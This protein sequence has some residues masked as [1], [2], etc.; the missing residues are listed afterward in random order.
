MAHAASSPSVNALP[1]LPNSTSAS[2]VASTEARRRQ[3]DAPSS[4]GTASETGGSAAAQVFEEVSVMNNYFGIGLDAKIASDFHNLR[5]EHPEKF[6]SR[7]RN[8]MWYGM[9]GGREFIN[10]TFRALDQHIE[11]F[12][13]GKPVA[14][15]RLQGLVV[16][17]IPSYMGGTDFWGQPDSREGFQP[18]QIDDKTL[19]VMAVFNV[20]QMGMARVGV[21]W[22]T[23]RIAQCKS[24]K[25]NILSSVDQVPVQVDGEA[26]MQE[27]GCIKVTHKGQAQMLAR[28]PNLSSI[29]HNWELRRRLRRN[30]GAVKEGLEL[31]AAQTDS[32]LGGSLQSA[33]SSQGGGTPM[34]GAPTGE[35]RAFWP[36]MM[37]THGAVSGISRLSRA[38]E[39]TSRELVP[40]AFTAENACT[41]LREMA[42][43]KKA[44]AAAMHSLMV[45]VVN[46][47]KVSK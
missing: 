47:V 38:V 10:R 35:V 16:L 27:P 5:E 24:L 20:A 4:N 19:E 31:G 32:G 23:A 15:P 14:L 40:L 11:L 46:S 6:R 25:I 17:N 18:S 1:V 37:A 12:C 41:R 28:D 45:D 34:R 44:D 33:S 13:D 3:S 21:R 8:M 9:L 22:R 43:Q 7:L 2:G 42:E 29:L 26:W 39:F 30:R 36:L